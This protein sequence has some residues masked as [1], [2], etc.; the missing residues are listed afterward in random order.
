MPYQEHIS[1][2][3][4]LGDFINEIGTVSHDMATGIELGKTEG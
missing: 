3:Q 1:K 2:I 4:R